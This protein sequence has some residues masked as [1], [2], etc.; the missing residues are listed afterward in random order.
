MGE[1]EDDAS[2]ADEQ[3]VQGCILF[4]NLS[5]ILKD[6]LLYFCLLSQLTTQ[7]PQYLQQ[8]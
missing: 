7:E 5:I 1:S 3:E 4:I 2:E 6:V 8:N